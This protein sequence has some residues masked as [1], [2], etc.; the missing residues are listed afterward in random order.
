[1]EQILIFLP[2]FFGL[3]V[4]KA[5][6]GNTKGEPISSSIMSYV[7]YSSFAWLA[8][9]LVSLYCTGI[10]NPFV[11]KSSIE[12]KEYL[13]AIAFSA[14]LGFLWFWKLKDFAENIIN[15]INKFLGR[16][17]IGL[18]SNVIVTGLRN[19]NGH[20]LQVMKDDKLL[21]SGMLMTEDIPNGVLIMSLDPTKCFENKDNQIAADRITEI[22]AYVD[23]KTGVI[24]KDIRFKNEDV[25]K[26]E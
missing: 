8:V 24:I 20:Y 19:A 3:A 2:G 14:V 1:M 13:L 22:I 4:Y 23:L 25:P 18:S 12:L 6:S 11:F 15:A 9:Y 7:L 21:C 26:S 17:E 16:H 5:F 10:K